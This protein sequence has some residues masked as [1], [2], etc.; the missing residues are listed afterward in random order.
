[1]RTL[2]ILLTGTM[3]AA[4]SPAFAQDSEADWTGA[5]VGVN[6]GYQNAKSDTTTVLTGA[7]AGESQATRDA[8]VNNFATSQSLD[9]VNFGGQ[10]GYNYSSGGAVLGI[11]AEATAYSGDS[12]IT[13][14]PFSPTGLPALGYTFTNRIDPKWTMAL[15]A[16][17]GA[18]SGNTL[19]YVEG[20][21]ALTRADYGADQTS[22]GGYSKSGRLTETTDGLIV[23]GGIEHKF[24]PNVSARLS[25]NY[26][27]QGSVTY[28]NAYNA[29]STFTSPVY[30]ETMT[31]DLR[32]HL[33]R[34]GLNFHF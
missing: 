28:V 18:A 24:S 2:S 14:G 30:T 32:L 29:G 16:K 5:Y 11:E 8:V 13:R 7:W 12:V 3:L 17:L 4:T 27:D 20:G 26:T 21:W 31:Q 6:I 23:G 25:Y 1:M 33:V 22:N 9:N 15:K 10:I 34:L 19:F